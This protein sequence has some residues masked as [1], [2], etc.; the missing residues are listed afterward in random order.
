[1]PQWHDDMDK[2]KITGGRSSPYRT[3]KRYER[4]GEAAETKVGTSERVV[5][6]IRGGGMKIKLLRTEEANVVDRSARKVQRVKVLR[7]VKNPVSVDYQRR[8]II[9]RGAVIETPLGEAMVT[10][11]PGQNGIVNA[12]L[13]SKHR[14]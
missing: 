14:A 1:M 11:R 12:V 8:G 7:V 2:R 9:T 5:R 6:R 13:I 3:K 4:G 10:S